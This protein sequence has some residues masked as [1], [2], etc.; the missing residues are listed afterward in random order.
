[1]IYRME[2]NHLRKVVG[3]TK[4]DRMRNETGKR[5]TKQGPM[6]KTIEKRR[7]NS[8]GHITRIHPVQIT[9]TV[10]EKGKPRKRQCGK[11]RRVWID[12]I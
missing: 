1:M 11:L 4:W 5:I 6:K 2:I 8:F 9:K 10:L 12:Q 3:K 7:P